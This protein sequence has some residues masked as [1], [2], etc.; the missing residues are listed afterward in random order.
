MPKGQRLDW[1][2]DLEVGFHFREDTKL[3]PKSSTHQAT[4]RQGKPRGAW[5]PTQ[6]P[7][8]GLPRITS[9]AGPEGPCQPQA[10]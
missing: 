9:C 7:S 3:S 10:F 4:G 8:C 5:A 2:T 1:I 6:A